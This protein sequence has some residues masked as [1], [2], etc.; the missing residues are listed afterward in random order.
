[1]QTFPQGAQVQRGAKH[2]Q[3]LFGFMRVHRKHKHPGDAGFCATNETH[4][5]DE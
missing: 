5:Q 4:R 1:M 3:R 2:R